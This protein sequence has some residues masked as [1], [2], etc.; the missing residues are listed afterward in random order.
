[1]QWTNSKG[2]YGAIVQTMHWLTAIFVVAG[3]LIGQFGDV[4]PRGAPRQYGLVV[5]MTL[6]QIVLTL[7]VIRLLWRQLNPPPPLEATP[8]GA[9]G[10]LAARASHVTLYAL[11]FAVPVLGMIVQLKRGH[12]LPVFGVFDLSSPW[13]A[14]R[15]IARSVLW[16]HSTLADALLILAGIHACAALLH[17]WLWRDRTLKRM[18]PG[19]V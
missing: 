17:H 9:L 4:L 14:D 10:T 13:P 19:R 2:R 12:A 11:L 6:G 5:H 3:F 1:M 18:L 8:L 15:N 16:L 7:L